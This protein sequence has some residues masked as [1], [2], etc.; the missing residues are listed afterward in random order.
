M[1]VIEATGRIIGVRDPVVEVEFVRDPRPKVHDVLYLKDNPN[2]RMLVIKSSDEHR[3]HC[4]SLSD[5]RL[6]ARGA[7]VVSSGNSLKLPVGKALLGRVIDL[8]GQP[9]DGLGDIV[10]VEQRP[11]FSDPLSYE[12]VSSKVEFLETGI[13]IIDLFAP[14]EKGGKVGLFGGS[15][16]G[17]TVLLTEILHN[18][19]NKDKENNKSVFCGIGERSREG[20]ELYEELKHTGVIEHVSL[21][22]GPMGESP[23]IRFLT[24]FAGATI[25]EYIRDD[26]GKN[27][28]C[29]IDNIFRF[30]Q[31]GNEMSILMG[32][33]PSEGGYQP[34][35]PT[36]VAEIHERLDSRLGKTI[37]TVEAIFLPEDDIFDPAAQSVFDYLDSS[38]VLSRDAYKEGRLP[39]V[40]IVSSGSDSLSPGNVSLDHYYTA[41]KAKSMLKKAES[42]ERIVSLVGESELSEEDRITYQRS[43]KLI[44]YMTQN[45]FVAANQTGKPGVYVPLND[46]VVVVRD[47]MDGKYDDVSE[48]KFLYIGGPSDI[49]K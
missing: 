9:R 17:K 34:T 35:L 33:I 16:V 36:E 6:I 41:T 4:I 14:L 15:G 12:E 49:K 39:A 8:F 44:N 13:K 1:E 22:Y 38:I 30:A 20:H 48:D 31:A 43:K 42:L 32:N 2:I 19:I 27:V 3:Y 23:S 7:R 45:F 47:I 18:I 24:A 26:L 29:F 11:I 46:T 10:G 21:I 28:L 40:D 25:A 37:T 5:V